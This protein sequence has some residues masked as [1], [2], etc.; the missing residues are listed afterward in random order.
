MI[1]VLY[2]EEEEEEEILQ[3]LDQ[4]RTA[5]AVVGVQQKRSIEIISRRYRGGGQGGR[6]YGVEAAESGVEGRNRGWRG[7][8]AGVEGAGSG[9]RGGGEPG[10]IRAE[11]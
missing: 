2:S 10:K 11:N 3:Y 4:R 7:R 5:N 8:E 6:G 1:P 9:D